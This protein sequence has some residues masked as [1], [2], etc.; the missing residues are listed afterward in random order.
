[1]WSTPIVRCLGEKYFY[2]TAIQTPI[3][4]MI[5][6]RRPPSLS[7]CFSGPAGHAWHIVPLSPSVRAATQV[8]DRHNCRTLARAAPCPSDRPALRHSPPS[9]YPP[10]HSHSLQALLRR[11]CPNCSALCRA[12]RGASPAVRASSR[13]SRYVH[14]RALQPQ[15]MNMICVGADTWR[16][17]HGIYTQAGSNPAFQV[18][19]KCTYAEFWYACHSALLHILVY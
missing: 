4:T 9:A 12:T 7:A 15:V 5:S 1:M 3:Q 6:P 18:D 13:S 14:Q 2:G 11:R 8:I 17:R 16:Y 19:Q 10:T